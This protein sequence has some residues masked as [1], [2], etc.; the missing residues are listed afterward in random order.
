MRDN[1]TSQ[2]AQEYDANVH[3]TIPRYHLFHEETL[4]VIKTIFPKPANWLDTG[5]GTGT[6]IARALEQFGATR[7]MA[8]DPSEGM[9]RLAAEKLANHEITY[10]LAGSEELESSNRFDIVTAIMV[11]HYL[12]EQ[13][14]RKATQNCFQLL[15]PGG[16]YITFETIKPATEQGIKIGLMRWRQAQLLHGKDPD[17]VEKHISRYGSELL[18]IT[19]EA[20]IQLLR[21]TGFS[22]V[23][24][25]WASGMQA[26]LYAIK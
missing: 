5:C 4:D 12:D 6:L 3:K 14:R 26:G 1:K 18:P 10:V 13:T 2:A 22:T 19:L 15:N 24:I 8:S 25:F 9:L 11:H 17:N 16:V 20:H 23:E 7:F 21:E